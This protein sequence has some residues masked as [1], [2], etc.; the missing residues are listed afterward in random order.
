MDNLINDIETNITKCK[1]T[2]RGMYMENNKTLRP[3]P[4]N[5]AESWVWAEEPFSVTTANVGLHRWHA[6]SA[7]SAGNRGGLIYL[8]A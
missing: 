3:G 7:T 8:L 1:L 6:T 2:G 4:Y 5:G